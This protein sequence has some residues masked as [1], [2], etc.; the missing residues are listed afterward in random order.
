LSG[1][2]LE[3]QIASDAATA[4]RSGDSAR[5][6]TLRLLRSALH[7][8]AIAARQPLSEDQVIDVLGRQAKQRRD[9]IEAYRNGG[10]DDLAQAEERELAIIQSYLPAP[11]SPAEIEG[12]ARARASELNAQ[13]PGD[14]GRVMAALKD[15]IRGR[16]DGK[17]V[18]EVVRAIL[19]E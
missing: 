8:A 10:R 6:T 17:T 7:D 15:D 4:M 14:M 19:A 5:L 3:A 2:A 12:L 9:S 13:G 1:T 16:A 18:S 11:L